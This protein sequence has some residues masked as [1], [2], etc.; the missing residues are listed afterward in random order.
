MPQA[1]ATSPNAR[2]RVRSGSAA[3]SRP[4]MRRGDLRGGAQ[5]PL[6][7]HLRLAVHAGH[8]P[9]VPVRLAAIFFGY[10]LAIH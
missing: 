3:A 8:L 5:V 2:C 1:A 10:R 7:D 4:S 6:G 9:Q